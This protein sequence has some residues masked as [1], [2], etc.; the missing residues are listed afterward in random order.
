MGGFGYDHRGNR[1]RVEIPAH[2]AG[3][4]HSDGRYSRGSIT[5]RRTHLMP[6]YQMTPAEEAKYGFNLNIWD[7]IRLL[8]TWAPLVG[9]AQRFVNSVDPYAK[10][11]V[12]AEAAE[13]VAS[14]TN[15][16]VDDQLV[17]MLADIAKTKEGEQLIRWCLMQAEAAR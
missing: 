5:S 16:Q 6:Q 13:W 12:V 3:I 9:Y 17:R 15:A 1:I 8:Q 7:Q 2:S 10:A 11:L 4:C 14:K